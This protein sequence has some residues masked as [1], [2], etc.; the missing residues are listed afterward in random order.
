LELAAG[1]RRKLQ[2]IRSAG[3]QELLGER[4][5]TLIAHAPTLEPLCWLERAHTELLAAFPNT[6]GDMPQQGA[7]EYRVIGILMAR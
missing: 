5:A 7:G 4:S 6:P 3:D 2:R 1:I